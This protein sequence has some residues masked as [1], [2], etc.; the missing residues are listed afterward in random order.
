VNPV[1]LCKK[2][3]IDMDKVVTIFQDVLKA[4]EGK[5]TTLWAKENAW[6]VKEDFDTV[7]KIVKE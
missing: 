3:A 4:D 6:T 2:I 1:K 7:M 5:V